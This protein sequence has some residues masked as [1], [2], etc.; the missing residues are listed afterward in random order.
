MAPYPDL[1]DQTEDP[2]DRYPVLD[3]PVETGV[4]FYD[5]KNAIDFEFP[6]ECPICK[7]DLRGSWESMRCPECGA[8]I[9]E[10]MKMLEKRAAQRSET[11]ATFGILRWVVFGMIPILVWVPV[12]FFLYRSNDPL[13][14]WM[15]LPTGLVAAVWGSVQAGEESRNDGLWWVM[16]VCL[17][18]CAGNLFVLILTF[19]GL[20]L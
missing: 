8:D 5:P 10:T 20:M 2:E 7:Y 15:T 6:D 18:L 14:M 9:R 4:D 17:T 19:K 13:W 3:P 12:A 1:I 11:L 16:A